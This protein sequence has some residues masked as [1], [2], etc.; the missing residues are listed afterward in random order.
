[1]AK[2][3]AA[4][5]IWRSLSPVVVVPKKAPPDA[6]TE[7]K[8]QMAIDYQHLNKQM[9]FVKSVDSNKKG[10]VS[11]IPLPKID[12]LF[13]RLNGAVIFSA[14]DIRQGYHHIALSEDAIPKTAL[15]LR[16]EKS[17]NF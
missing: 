15:I 9:P 3:A 13:A 5:T 12:Q 14:I 7:D 11:F 1:M 10:A 16:Q 2:L 17:G 8:H 4:G 6:P